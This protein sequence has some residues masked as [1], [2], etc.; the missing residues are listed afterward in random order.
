MS[1]QEN[2]TRGRQ[3]RATGRMVVVAVADAVA[4]AQ[5]DQEAQQAQQAAQAKQAKQAKRDSGKRWDA[6]S[7]LLA[8]AAPLL[9][10]LSAMRKKG[11]GDEAAAPNKYDMLLDLLSSAAAAPAAQ[12]SGG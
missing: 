5:R 2:N 9:A 8:P 11:K 4:A 1:K 10:G 12:V 6:L 7:L 3:Q